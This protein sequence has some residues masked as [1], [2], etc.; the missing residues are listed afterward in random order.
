MYGLDR[1]DGINKISFRYMVSV[2][3]SASLYK[4]NKSMLAGCLLA[5][6]SMAEHID[7][8]LKHFHLISRCIGRMLV[9]QWLGGRDES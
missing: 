1:W 3:C 8:V 2:Q 5:C 7:S 4:W 9:D 6:L